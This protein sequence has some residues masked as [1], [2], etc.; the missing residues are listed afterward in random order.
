MAILLALSPVDVGKVACSGI[1]EGCWADMMH[2]QHLKWYEILSL[3]SFAFR[4]RQ[5]RL[6]RR[7]CLSDGLLLNEA[8]PKLCH[9]ALLLR[10]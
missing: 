3:S 8:H 4:I 7:G 10:V 1:A 2:A 9:L 6:L 5:P